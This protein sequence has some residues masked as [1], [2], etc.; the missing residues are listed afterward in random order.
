MRLHRPLTSQ[1]LPNVAVLQTGLGESFGEMLRGTSPRA[2]R[3]VEDS[4]PT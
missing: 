1:V 4:I 3:P 2:P